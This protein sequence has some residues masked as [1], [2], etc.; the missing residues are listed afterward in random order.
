MSYC[1]TFDIYDW[2]HD[3]EYSTYEQCYKEAKKKGDNFYIGKVHVNYPKIDG[4]DIVRILSS[5]VDYDDS[6]IARFSD[7]DIEDLEEYI[8]LAIYHWA[9][10]R[11]IDLVQT[12]VELYGVVL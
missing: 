12:G 4:G 10:K 9:S 11:G 7:E 8:N 3:K 6:Y 2:S 1:Y 5:Y